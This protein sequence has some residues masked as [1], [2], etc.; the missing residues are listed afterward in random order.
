MEKRTLKLGN[1]EVEFSYSRVSKTI[2]DSKNNL[3]KAILIPKETK[4]TIK[5]PNET[6]I[7]RAICSSRDNFTYEMG[8]KTAMKN[9]FATSRIADKTTRKAEHTKIWNDY[10]K[11]KKGGRW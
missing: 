5:T 3:T 10:N 9:A 11:L 4:V 7:G 6:L 1:A 2:R 8:R